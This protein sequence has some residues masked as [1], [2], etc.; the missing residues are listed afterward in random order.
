MNDI[1]KKIPSIKIPFT[2]LSL[3]GYSR[4]ARNTA[5]YIPEMKVMLDCGIENEYIPDHIFITH[6]HADHSKNIPMNI[7][8][9]SNTKSKEKKKVN[10]YVPNAMTDLTKDFIHS[11]YVMSKNN[12]KHK[13]HSKYNLIGVNDNS[14]IEIL[15]RN[16]K[17]IIE[18]IKCDHTVPCVGYG[19]IELRT[20]LKE[21]YLNLSKEEII[22][23]KKSGKE[24]QN[25]VEFPL[26]CYLGDST[27]K[28][29]SNDLLKK[30]PVIMTEC[31]FLYPDQKE[32]A[33][34]KKHIHIDNLDPILNNFSEKTFI[35]YHFSNRYEREEIINFFKQRNYKNIIIWI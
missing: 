35:L 34:H 7:V 28:V 30:Y 27:E 4:A 6:C 22:N 19:F 9:L 20:K 17:F 32:N 23:I 5:F 21:E 13:A 16:K 1:W 10:Y 2:S 18:I 3:T 26:F 29:F 33:R 15:I 8:Q 14:R 25:I 11:F 12:L 31:T 24:I